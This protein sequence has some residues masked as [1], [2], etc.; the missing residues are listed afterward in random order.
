MP[1]K[2]A[3][4]AARKMPRRVVKAGHR[5][6]IDRVSF[7]ASFRV[8]EAC[9]NGEENVPFLRGIFPRFG[10][11]VITRYDDQQQSKVLRGVFV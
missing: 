2:R 7:K 8:P 10:C 11:L 1:K 6:Q 4:A 5:R 3:R 9:A